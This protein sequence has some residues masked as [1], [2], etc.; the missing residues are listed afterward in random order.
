MITKFNYRGRHYILHV[1]KNETI[2]DVL[3]SEVATRNETGKP[4]TYNVHRDVKMFD[5]VI[6]NQVKIAVNRMAAEID[7]EL[8]NKED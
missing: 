1:T 6:G 4:T 8:M 3:V 7:I 2:C 5:K